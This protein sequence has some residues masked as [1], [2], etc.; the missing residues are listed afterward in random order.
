MRTAC[1]SS[2]S[3]CK[4]RNASA[5]AGRADEVPSRL[6]WGQESIS[7]GAGP[8]SVQTIP[9]P[10]SE[11]RRPKEIRTP[12]PELP[13]QDGSRSDQAILGSDRKSTRLNSS[14]LGI[15]YAV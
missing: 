4:S 9:S 2:A 5:R 6:I 7:H 12:N 14:H 11:D 13:Q 10:K 3:S 8:R 15:S 1:C